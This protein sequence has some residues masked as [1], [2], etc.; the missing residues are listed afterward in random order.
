[1]QP[2]SWKRI[3]KIQCGKPIYGVRSTLLNSKIGVCKLKKKNHSDFG[4]PRPVFSILPPLSLKDFG[5]YRGP[6]Q[7]GL[8]LVIPPLS[9]PSQGSF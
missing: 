1:M 6:S 8:V 4:H 2:R 9:E 5:H 7:C 3:I